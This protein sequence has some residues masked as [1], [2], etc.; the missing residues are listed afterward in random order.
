MNICVKNEGEMKKVPK[1]QIISADPLSWLLCF[2]E[3][4]IT[5]VVG[6]GDQL[7]LF[8]N[9][10]DDLE[11]LMEGLMVKVTFFITD[12]RTLEEI[13]Y[14]TIVQFPIIYN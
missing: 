7:T 9:W 1:N 3:W 2:L 11:N 4:G 12:H 10:D 6:C 8:D 5:Y 14:Y 13:L